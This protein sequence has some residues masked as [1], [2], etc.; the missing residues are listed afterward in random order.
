[1]LSLSSSQK[2]EG[3]GEEAL[4]INS[5]SLRLSPR[6]FLARRERKNA[7]SALRAEHNWSVARSGMAAWKAFGLDGS[8]S[9]IPTWLRLT[10]ALRWEY[11]ATRRAVLTLRPPFSS[12]LAP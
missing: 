12:F 10:A 5:P 1:L 3:R 8:V 9:N 2:E 4:F 6:S 11:Q 7:T